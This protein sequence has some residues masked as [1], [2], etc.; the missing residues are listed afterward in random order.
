MASRI[1]MYCKHERNCASGTMN[2]KKEDRISQLSGY[3]SF[4]FRRSQVCVCVYISFWKQ[5]NMS[6]LF[7]WIYR[8]HQG[9]KSSYDCFLPHPAFWQLLNYHKNSVS[10]IYYRKWICFSW[11]RKFLIITK[12]IE[13][14]VTTSVFTNHIFNFP[15]GIT[16]MLSH[17]CFLHV[18]FISLIYTVCVCEEYS[19]N[20][21][22]EYGF[23]Y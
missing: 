6:K 12:F 10:E 11:I 18:T 15:Y 5:A 21:N 4:V 3:W 20:F 17:R 7:N 16:G 14:K 9:N 22:N 19:H 1:I 23:F 2:N 13:Y 8:Y